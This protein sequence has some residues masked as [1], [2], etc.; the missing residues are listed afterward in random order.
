MKMNGTT[1]TIV[2]VLLAGAVALAASALAEG[3]KRSAI[4]NLEK[5][6]KAQWEAI[7]EFRGDM[8]QQAETNGRIDERTKGMKDTL[9]DMLREIRQLGFERRSE[10]R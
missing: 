7:N 6:D 1:N 4:D 10:N 5:S 2:T 3:E 8:K 9:S